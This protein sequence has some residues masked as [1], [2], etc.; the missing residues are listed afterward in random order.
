MIKN[1]KGLI[2]QLLIFIVVV[3]ISAGFIFAMY[4]S[5]NQTA[6]EVFFND[7]L[8]SVSM[9]ASAVVDSPN[10]LLYTEQDTASQ[11]PRVLS[12]SGVID[13]DKITPEKAGCARKGPYIWNAV[14][15][16]SSGVQ[17][18]ISSFDKADCPELGSRSLP[19]IIRDSG[20]SE[21]GKA[22]VSVASMDA[23]AT[24]SKVADN[25]AY[26]KLINTGSCISEFEVTAAATNSTSGEIFADVQ[27]DCLK[28]KKTSGTVGGK[29]PGRTLE[30]KCTILNGDFSLYD[31]KV[32]ISP[33]D[34]PYYKKEY[35]VSL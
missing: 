31:L 15:E 1:N 5:G 32:E 18:T 11:P 29:S 12:T 20:N 21:T 25:E 9:I 35:R 23:Q 24:F 3:A 30:F 14:V 34:I 6:G 28:L 17:K 26:I 22:T 33:A 2:G 27:V 13:W 8:R 10:C 7:D 19:V 4:K 16:K